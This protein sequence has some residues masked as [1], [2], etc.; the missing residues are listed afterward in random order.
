[1][2][3]FFILLYFFQNVFSIQIN[4]FLDSEIK[5]YELQNNISISTINY[6][7]IVGNWYELFSTKNNSFNFHNKNNYS[8]SSLTFF[9]YG[10]VFPCEYEYLSK[11]KYHS[12]FGHLEFNQ[13][14]Y[15]TKFEFISQN[16]IE[17]YSIFYISEDNDLLGIMKC[18]NYRLKYNLGFYIFSKNINSKQSTKIFDYLLQKGLD[19]KELFNFIPINHNYC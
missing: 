14:N 15:F 12:T 17:N 2:F 19:K 18:S 4:T 9:K 3:K 5:C 6:D 13:T 7:N 10:N 1:M 11:G 8:C 16:N